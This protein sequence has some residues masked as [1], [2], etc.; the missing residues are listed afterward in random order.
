MIPADAVIRRSELSAV[1]V[2]RDDVVLLRQ[3]R[4]GRRYGDSI[5]VLA[6]LDAGEAVALDPVQAGIYLKD[7]QGAD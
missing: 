3:L 4:L 5:E 6:G 7:R 1:Y 2:V